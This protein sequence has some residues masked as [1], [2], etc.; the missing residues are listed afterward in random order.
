MLLDQ[1][2]TPF[3]RSNPSVLQGLLRIIPFLSFGELEK[4]RILVERFK[5]CCSFDKWASLSFHLQNERTFKLLKLIE[6]FSANTESGHILKS[7]WLF[8]ICVSVEL[9]PDFVF[10]GTTRS[11]VQM[12][13]CFWIV[14]VKSPLESKIT[15]TG[16]SSKILFC[17]KESHRVHWTT[18]RNISPMPKSRSSLFLWPKLVCQSCWHHKTYICVWL[19][20]SLLFLNTL[21]SLDADVW[22][23]FLS[24][25]A[26]PFILRLLRGLAT[27]HPPTQVLNVSVAPLGLSNAQQWKTDFSGWLWV[28]TFIEMFDP[29]GR[30]GIFFFF[31]WM[32]SSLL[33]RC[34]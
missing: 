14:S 27:Q 24:R 21:V 29:A 18:W 19:I 22:K 2:N 32:S 16:I 33:P 13:K 3:V 20:P 25:P 10:S 30:L 9:T 23:K 12:T 28:I 7:S 15:A 26:L 5:P 17:R 1:I 34:W 4:M 11:I 31:D 6:T 8:Q